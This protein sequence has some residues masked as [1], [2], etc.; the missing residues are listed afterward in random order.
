MAHL[1]IKKTDSVIVKVQNRTLS[2]VKEKFIHAL[3]Q[4]K[5]RK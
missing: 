4:A 1:M 2:E 5:E 3:L